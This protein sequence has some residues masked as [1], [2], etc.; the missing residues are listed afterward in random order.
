MISVFF[1]SPLELQVPVR[2]QLMLYNLN[3]I[4]KNLI[5]LFKR[6]HKK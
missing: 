6:K 1:F 4:K 5:A 3:E 2:N